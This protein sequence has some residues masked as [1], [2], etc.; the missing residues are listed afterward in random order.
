MSEEIN[1]TKGQIYYRKHKED[2]KKRARDYYHEHKDAI[3]GRVK[4]YY[5]NNREECLRRVKEYRENNF[6]E[7]DKRQKIAIWRSRGVHHENMGELYD[8]YFTCEFCELCGCLLTGG[9]GNQGK[10]LDHDHTKEENNF[11]NVVCKKC[12]NNRDNRKRN[13]KGQYIKN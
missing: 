1:L 5:T 2:L 12:N 3:K 7:W 13:E 10:C 11:R 4:E 6:Y 9:L 8:Y